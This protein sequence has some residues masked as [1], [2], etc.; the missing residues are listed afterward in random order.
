MY[1][2]QNILVLLFIVVCT[3]CTNTVYGQVNAISNKGFQS[4]RNAIT[5]IL[6][7]STK[8][9]WWYGGQGKEKYEIRD[10]EEAII[11]LTYAIRIDSNV[12][13]FYYFRG[14]SQAF[15]KQSAGALI[16]YQKALELNPDYI[17]TLNNL[18][19]EYIKRREFGG[20]IR[21]FYNYIKRA[22][23]N[24]RM[25]F[26]MNLSDDYLLQLNT[27]GWE[28]IRNGDLPKA[29]RYFTNY[30]KLASNDP[31]AYLGLALI[32]FEYG[33]FERSANY[34][35]DAKKLLPS[36]Y[37]GI[38]GLSELEKQ[39]WYYSVE[40]KE[41]LNIMFEQLSNP[42][43]DLQYIT[44]NS[45]GMFLLSFI[46]IVLGFVALLIFIFRIKRL[47]G[48]IFYLGLLNIFFGLRFLNEN[49]LVK[50]SEFPAP[51]FWEF[52]MPIIALITP[53]VFILFIRYFIGWGWRYSILGLLIYSIIQGLFKIVTEYY[54]SGQSIYGTS[55][56]VFGFL[57]TGVLFFHMFLPEMRKNREVQI[58]GGGLGFYFLALLN[59][60]LAQMQWIPDL[61]SFDELA[62]LFFNLCLVY[63]AI[64]RVTKS[65]KEF[66]AVK[67][68]LETARNI[69]NGILPEKN[70]KSNEYEVSS[71]YLPMELIGGDYY[72]YQIHDDSHIGVLVADVS[73]HG[74]SAALIAS[75]LKVAFTSQVSNA[76]QPAIV[77]QQINHSLAGQLNNEFITAG[78]FSFDIE[79]KKL[80]FSSAGHP[81]LILY[82][83]KDNELKEI[84]VKG[85]PIGV[86]P[87]TTFNE[88][89]M[90]LIKGDR[91][92]LYTD[93]ISDVFNAAGEAFGKNRFI[94]L[95]KET[96]NLLVEDATSDILKGIRKWSGKM[97][98]E[99]YEDDITMVI[100]DVL[101][102]VTNEKKIEKRYSLSIKNQLTEIEKIV[103]IIDKLSVNWDMNLK[104]KNQINLVVEEIFANIVFY[105]F[106]DKI[107]HIIDIDFI[108]TN[109]NI[110]IQ[111]SDNGKQFNI[112]KAD[113]KIEQGIS[114]EDRK[115]GG[116]GIPIIKT[117][118]DSLEYSRIDDLNVIKITKNIIS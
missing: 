40:D 91:L 70:P 110:T 64:S 26:R 36:L 3:V 57:A 80:I 83:R 61:V 86:F 66:F 114:I 16:D 87:E 21:Y 49:T 46:Y 8:S 52:G 51:Y 94:E 59:D 102:T 58:I 4:N 90:Q 12:S 39:V 103:K 38:E 77:L 11:Y 30:I 48:Y 9:S 45:V 109:Q 104:F 25:F 84:R 37:Q 42:K 32:F 27:L 111:I 34:L 95:I 19:W 69:Q 82:R 98:E 75:M 6:F 96:K 5:E 78:Y 81:P 20:A 35:Y 97:E 29:I 62:Y 79:T 7:D 99:T 72:D 85:I 22:P 56:T 107:E 89:S 24:P 108:K 60:N 18:G 50:I 43:R 65:E 63:V 101:D 55:D 117:L 2:S 113:D 71:A 112:L 105:A 28:S 116:L 76:K 10:Y 73:G 13:E 14:N 115:V 17:S 100:F 15:I 44:K 1:K 106:D 53:I 31:D 54:Q 93:G 74:I 88:S 47:E 67:Q 33:D 68:D 23:K 92:I 41:R 118:V